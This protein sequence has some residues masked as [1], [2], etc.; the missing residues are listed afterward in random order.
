[1]RNNLNGVG[2]AINF[3]CRLIQPSKERVHP[4]YEY[5]GDEDI[6]QEAHER[7]SLDIAYARL[8]ELF[9]TNTQLNN[10]G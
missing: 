10:V 9:S 1:M 8:L 4:T 2:V 5:I 7:I 3:V 6:T